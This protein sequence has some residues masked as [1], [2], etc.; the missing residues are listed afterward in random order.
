MNWLS[1]IAL[2]LTGIGIIISVI[3]LIQAQ[4][5]NKAV[6]QQN[7]EKELA[8]LEQELADVNIQITEIKSKPRRIYGAIHPMDP[9]YK[10]VFAL[11][12]KKAALLKRKQRIE[13]QL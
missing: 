11:E 1:I 4:R 9:E 6:L 2:V 10:K 13:Q 5:A 12:E 8:E 3:A 7:R